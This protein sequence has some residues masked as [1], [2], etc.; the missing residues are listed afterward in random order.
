MKKPRSLVWRD[1]LG[2]VSLDL[3]FGSEPPG[4]RTRAGNDNANPARVLPVS[5]ER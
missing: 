1:Q 5:V 3:E 2:A 4:E